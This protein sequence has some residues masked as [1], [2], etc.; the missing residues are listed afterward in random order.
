MADKRDYYEVLGVQKTANDDDLKKAYRQMAKKY[1]PDANPGDKSA[2]ESFKEVNEAYAVLS[3]PQKRAAYDQYGHAAFDPAMGG[4]GGNPY[5]GVN[6]DMGD[7]FS[8]VFGE[9]LGDI[10]G[11]GF[12]D[13]FGGGGRRARNG[14]RRG[15]DLQTNIQIRF[16]EAV[17]G[18]QK[19]IQLTSS[20]AC[21]TCKGSGA[22]PGT[23][24]ESCKHCG[25]TG[26]E[27]VQQQTMFGTVTSVRPC[28]ICNGEGKIVRD[29][30]PDCRGTGKVRTTK[31]LTVNVPK[32][33][34]NGTVIRLTGK[35]EPGEKGGPSGDLLIT[36]YVQSHK[37]F[38][39][40]GM[41][42][43]LD[44]PITFVQAALGD[45]LTIPTLDGSEKYT[46]KPGTQPG[47]IVTLRGKGVPSLKNNKSVGDLIIKLVV[48]VPTQ[49]SERQ[50]QRLRDFADEMGE[51]YKN[52][53]QTFFEKIKSSFK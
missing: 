25:G 22:K 47:T 19:D 12:G 13:M 37:H 14:P 6:F 28:T 27:R 34:D 1:H 45:E 35:G 29:P 7:I 21:P 31:T 16:E 11:G 46:I 20:D 48:T 40:Q 36:V 51:E 41:N 30:C 5:G 53:K 17:F 33:V 15:A 9:G 49:M 43:Y 26:Q 23:T 4:A 8:S 2:E 3:D 10:F 52:Q 44:V 24:A 39:R 38:T 50:K 18:T 32:G 42:L